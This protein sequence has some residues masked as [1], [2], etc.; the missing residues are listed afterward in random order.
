MQTNLFTKEQIN[1]ES[2]VGE[3]IKGAVNHD[4]PSKLYFS[5]PGVENLY[6]KA[7]KALEENKKVIF[8]TKK[9]F[10]NTDINSES[11][12]SSDNLK[13]R[14]LEEGLSTSLFNSLL[15]PNITGQKVL[16]NYSLAFIEA[17]ASKIYHEN[18]FNKHP[19]DHFYCAQGV[20]NIGV[21]AEF[22]KA[23]EVKRNEVIS[24]L[25]PANSIRAFKENKYS[26]WHSLNTTTDIKNPI[27]V[28]L[29]DKESEKTKAELNLVSELITN[30][31]SPL[32]KT[33][34]DDKW[35]LIIPHHLNFQNIKD[36]VELS[37]TQNK[38]DNLT[39]NKALNEDDFEGEL[40]LEASLGQATR[41]IFELLGG[42]YD[43]VPE[44]MLN[45]EGGSWS[46]IALENSSSGRHQGINSMHEVLHNGW[47]KHPNVAIPWNYLGFDKCQ[48][49]N[50]KL[51]DDKNLFVL[52]FEDS[53]KGILEKKCFLEANQ[54][55]KKIL[56]ESAIYVTKFVYREYSAIASKKYLLSTKEIML[57]AAKFIA[58]L[59]IYNFNT[60]ANNY[61]DKLQEANIPQELEGLLECVAYSHI[62]L[63]AR[64]DFHSCK[65]GADCIARLKCIAKIEKR[66]EKT[67][68]IAVKNFKNKLNL[69]LQKDIKT[70]FTTLA[71]LYQK[72]LEASK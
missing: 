54:S 17:Q 33:K 20:C 25:L 60:E 5:F 29:I 9:V 10:K 52:S 38:I 68:P 39:N 40:E 53:S 36:K 70:E 13:N 47:F 31:N 27:K 61:R 41:V 30:L 12:L 49:D 18:F 24:L 44:A 72:E 71:L 56:N 46:S 22:V 14:K 8:K 1:Q 7:K 15:T 55:W 59:S 67:S 57:F 48:L 4:S 65:T 28:Y 45:F 35:A 26:S 3:L 43:N 42:D 6:S 32:Y 34:I 37:I 16:G 66:L 11:F 58:N 69:L 64:A 51:I 63:T 21:F 50:K 62:L 2:S 19:I 23:F